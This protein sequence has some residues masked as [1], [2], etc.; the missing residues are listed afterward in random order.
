MTEERKTI[1]MTVLFTVIWCLVNVTAGSTTYHVDPNGNDDENGLSWANAFATIQKGITSADGGNPDD[2]NH[3]DVIDVNSG[4]YVTG[5]ITV[6]N[7]NIRFRFQENV[8]VQ[9]RSRFDANDPNH[10]D[11]TSSFRYPWARLFRVI[12]KNNIIFDGNDAVLQMNRDEYPGRF[13][14]D[15]YADVNVDSNQIVITNHNY[16]VGDRIRYSYDP[17]PGYTVIG[18]LTRLEYYYAIIVNANTIKLASSF[19]DANDGNEIDLTTKPASSQTHFVYGGENRHVMFLLI[20]TNIEIRDLT[21]KDSGGDGIEVG[22]YYGT[23]SSEKIV[24]ENVTCDNN[25]RAGISAGAVNDLT[26]E[27]C[28][29]KNT[30]GTPPQYGIGFEP[31]DPNY[32]LKNIEVRNCKIEGTAGYGIGIVPWKLRE[33]ANSKD[34]DLLFEDIFIKDCADGIKI[35]GIY[36]DGADGSITFKNVT[37]EGGRYGL[38]LRKSSQKAS[39]SFEEC[40]WRDIDAG[41]HPIKIVLNHSQNYTIEYPVGVDFNNCQIFDDVNRPAIIFDGDSNDTLYEISGDLYVK[42]DNRSGSLYDW[43]GADTNNVD[44]NLISGVADFAR[45]CNRTRYKWYSS[46]QSAI[47]DSDDGDVIEVS[48]TTHYEAINFNNKAVTLRSFDPY[49]RDVVAATIIDGDAPR[50]AV[51]TFNDGESSNSI[52]EG[53]TLTGGKYGVSCSNSSSPVIANCIIENNKSHG[54]YC[55]S[56]SPEIMYNEIRFNGRDGINSSATTPLT[57]K[58]N[59]VYGNKRDGMEFS[60]AMS[61]GVVRNNTIV[62][63]AGYGIYVSSGMT[64]AISNCILWDNKRNDLKGCNATYSCI[65]D[66]Y[67]GVGNISN[68]PSFVDAKNKVFHLDSDSPCIEAGDPNGD[69]YGE[70]DIDGQMRVMVTE[71]DIGADEAAYFPSNHNDYDEWVTVDRPDCWC[72]PRQ[73]RGDADNFAEGG[74]KLNY[75]VGSMDLDVL[76]AA[77]NKPLGDIS[78]NEICADS[79]HSPAGRKR[80]R[81]STNDLNILLANWQI[82]NGPDPN[83]FDS[84]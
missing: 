57:A 43:N 83:C 36:D 74:S 54:I 78:G 2:P 82:E 49:D 60:L 59:L 3:Y 16:T 44:V 32:L 1:L 23:T 84:N 21:C 27:N 52:V 30:N 66:E 67:T 15:A 5:P 34:I 47:N 31:S 19:S 41:E 40:V 68:Y 65:E 12:N 20:C 8:T 39:V 61:A 75:W 38:Y 58:N 53:I 50:S 45:S 10:P 48:P 25:Y 9:A 37:V 64:P 11:D 7:D 79:D 42:N 76:T 63:N 73:C 51:I 46:I 18:G 29:I 56:G 13:E 22:G 4:T 71:V 6:D 33:Y 17:I 62:N 69:Y 70:V 24:I 81:V 26:I 55:S 28:V 14:F 35:K 80:W 72:Y 77:W